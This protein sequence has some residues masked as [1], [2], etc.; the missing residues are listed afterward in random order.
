MPGLDF[1]RLAKGSAAES[2]TEPRRI[3]SALPTKASKYRYPRDVQTDVW[4]RW[5]ER[6]TER[7]LVIKMNTGGG[8]TAVGLVVLKS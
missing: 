8:K 3:F 1:N 6:R 4:E 2:A 7:D 5:H